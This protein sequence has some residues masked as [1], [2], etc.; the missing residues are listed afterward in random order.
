MQ[1]ITKLHGLLLSEFRKEDRK[2]MFTGLFSSTGNFYFE[3]TNSLSPL[4]SFVCN[5]F[6]L[7]S[8][9]SFVAML[10]CSKFN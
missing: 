6:F 1:L 2:S 10:V 7:Y 3:V 5:D 4:L 8:P 9:F